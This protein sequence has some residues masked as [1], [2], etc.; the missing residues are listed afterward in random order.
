MVAKA[1]REMIIGEVKMIMRAFASKRMAKT[2]KI[3][4]KAVYLI[5]VLTV[6]RRRAVTMEAVIAHQTLHSNW[7]RMLLAVAYWITYCKSIPHHQMMH[8]RT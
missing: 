5:A 7:Q 2:M 8:H 1:V 4:I 6:I 3:V